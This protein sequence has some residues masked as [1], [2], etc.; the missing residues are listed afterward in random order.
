MATI[1][2]AGAA[3][4]ATAL[5]FRAAVRT[6]NRM[7]AIKMRGS[8]FEPQMT[9][10]EASMILNVREDATLKE[11]KDSHVRVMMLNHPDRQGSPYIAAKINE[12]KDIL[13]K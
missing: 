4:A 6:C 1:V 2:A 3:V 11:I 13:S 8:G 7:A 5:L 10:K 9:H 12:A